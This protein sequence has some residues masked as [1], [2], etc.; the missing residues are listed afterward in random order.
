M[1]LRWGGIQN[2]RPASLT[3]DPPQSSLDIRVLELNSGLTSSKLGSSVSD[4]VCP[5]QGADQNSPEKH[6]FCSIFGALK[7]ECLPFPQLVHLRG[8]PEMPGWTSQTHLLCRLGLLSRIK[9]LCVISRPMA[10]LLEGVGLG[11]GEFSVAGCWRS[12]RCLTA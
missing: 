11:Q 7:S 12:Q 9:V 1:A 6:T 5:L 10:S 3:S 2:P 8:S 4:P